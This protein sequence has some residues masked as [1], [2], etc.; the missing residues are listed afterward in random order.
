MVELCTNGQLLKFLRESQ[1]FR[2]LTL[3][4]MMTIASDVAQGMSYLTQLRFIHRDLAARNILVD[5]KYTCKISDF[6]MSRG[7]NEGNYYRSRGGEVPVRWTAPEALGHN[8]FSEYSDVWSYG[9]TLYEI[10]SSGNKPY[11]NIKTNAEV[12]IRCVQPHSLAAV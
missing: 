9:V 6:G 4:A 11:R 10:F 1:K 12:W 2:V 5:S 3:N 7:G 8:K